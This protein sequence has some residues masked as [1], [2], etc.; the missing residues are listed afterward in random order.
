MAPSGVYLL[1]EIHSAQLISGQSCVTHARERRKQHGH[2]S[3]AS[4]VFVFN[5][6]TIPLDRV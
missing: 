5:L 6:E 2:C 4:V 1:E 3:F